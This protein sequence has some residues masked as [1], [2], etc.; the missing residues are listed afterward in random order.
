MFKRLMTAVLGTRHERERK[1][2]QPIVDE[3]NEHY[4][5]LQTVSEAELRGQTGKLRGI[6]RERTGE[7]EAAIA[8]L[9]EQ[10]RNAADPGERDRLDNELSGQDGRGGR[11]GELREATAEVLDEILPEAFA[12]VREA[13]RRMLGTT[14]QVKGHDLTW[15]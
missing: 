14:V 11:E 5:R 2:I 7:L 13:A 8:S 1:R 6:I 3:I 9:R 15:D 10:K 4:A 12:T